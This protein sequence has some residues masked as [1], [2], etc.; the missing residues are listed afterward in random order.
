MSQ[1][2]SPLASCLTCREVKSAKGIFSHFIVAHT[3]AG[4][5]RVSKPKPNNKGGIAAAKKASSIRKEYNLNPVICGICNNSHSYDARNNKFCSHSCA[6]TYTNAQR[7]LDGWK[8]PESAKAKLRIAK[9]LDYTKISQCA[10]CSKFFPG[11]KKS[12]SIMCRKVLLS[13]AGAI[14]GKASN[15]VRCKRSKAEIKLYELC[16]SLDDTIQHNKALVDKWDCDIFL[17]KHNLC[18]FW[19]GPWHYR[20]M[21]LYNHD[22]SKVQARDSLKNKLFTAAGYTVL[23]FEDR[24]YTP[25]SAFEYIKGIVGHPGD[26]PGTFRLSVECSTN[27]S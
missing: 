7:R 5:D 23:T 6:A 16:T 24:H 18:I 19:N 20:E 4:Y 3:K 10:V 14:G 15:L 22:L 8:M 27:M 26:A 9:T 13:D 25:D 12:C 1:Y 11:R 2:K 21:G 17:P